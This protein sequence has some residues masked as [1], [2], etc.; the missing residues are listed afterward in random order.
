MSHFGEE[1][2]KGLRGFA[3]RGFL[4]LDFQLC[5]SFPALDLECRQTAPGMW[6]RKTGGG[7]ELACSFSDGFRR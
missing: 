7:V 5:D 1:A 3:L 4:A 2:G 6:R